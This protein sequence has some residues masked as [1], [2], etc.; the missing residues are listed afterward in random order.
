MKPTMR[1]RLVEIAISEC[2]IRGV[3]DELY[4]FC[5]KQLKKAKTNAA[6]NYWQEQSSVLHKAINEIHC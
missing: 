2:G 6:R 5:E 1:T 3:V 4:A